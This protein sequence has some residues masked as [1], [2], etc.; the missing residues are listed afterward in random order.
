MIIGGNSCHVDC[1]RWAARLVEVSEGGGGG[2]ERGH[3]PWFWVPTAKRT[4]GSVAVNAVKASKRGA[5]TDPSTLR[6][7]GCK[8][9]LPCEGSSFWLV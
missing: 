3:S 1:W 6:R 7:R 2:R 5:V 4:A 8:R 9:G